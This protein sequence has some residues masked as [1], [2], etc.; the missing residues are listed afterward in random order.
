MTHWRYIHLRRDRISPAAI[1]GLMIDDAPRANVT[2]DPAAVTCPKCLEA[3]AL[4]STDIEET[5]P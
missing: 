2:D 5:L 3:G 4:D 1:C